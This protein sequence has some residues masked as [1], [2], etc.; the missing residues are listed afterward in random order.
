MVQE[1]TG[2]EIA[3]M[4]GVNLSDVNSPPKVPAEPLLMFP[5][6]SLHMCGIK[7]STALPKPCQKLLQLATALCAGAG[8]VELPVPGAGVQLRGGFAV[9]TQPPQAQFL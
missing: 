1:P 5:S 6:S 7:C 8:V 3:V 2:Y 4:A 9:V